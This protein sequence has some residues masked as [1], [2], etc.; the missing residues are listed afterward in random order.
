MWPGRPVSACRKQD[1]TANPEFH[2]TIKSAKWEIK[3]P[4]PIAA[5]LEPVTS[6]HFWSYAD[7]TLDWAIVSSKTV[8]STDMGHY[9]ATMSPTVT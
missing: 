3:L 6:N 1:S 2:A 4:L 8:V 7:K 5:L 9:G